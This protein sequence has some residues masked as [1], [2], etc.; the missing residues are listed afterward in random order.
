VVS[1]FPLNSSC[2]TYG[3][4]CSVIVIVKPAMPQKIELPYRISDIWVGS[5][6]TVN[7]VMMDFFV[8]VDLCADISVCG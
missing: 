7:V 6:Q 8:P 1:I 2:F 3:P 5:P 4:G